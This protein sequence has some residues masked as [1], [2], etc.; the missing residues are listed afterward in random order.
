MAQTSTKV[1]VLYVGDSGVTLG[2]VGASSN[3]TY[4]QRGVLIENAAQR[5]IDAW[6][7]SPRYEVTYM[8]GWDALA[9]FPETP[10]ALKA[11][12]V[13]MLS[14]VDSDSIVLYPTERSTRAPMGPNRL[15][16]I[17]DYVWQ[18][19]ALAMIGGYATFVG[20]H[21]AG[22]WHGTPVE[23]ALP[24][25]CLAIDDDR[26]ETPEG[27]TLEVKQPQHP[28]MRGIEWSPSPIFN[29][30]NR[31]VPKRSAKVLAVFK[32]TGDPA[33]VVWTF[34]KGRAMAFASDI[35]PHWGAG[36]QNWKYYEQFWNQALDWLGSR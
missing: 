12:D 13:V 18:G 26:A 20:R 19:G 31:I 14:D 15:K 21:N 35:A 28:L 17:R 4:D 34:G 24:V 9:K 33:I 11:F 16:S 27:V 36:F 7:K 22:N 6:R 5:I 25:D 23:E 8:T 10:E 3:F 30:Y 1:R 29:G 2:A 32:E